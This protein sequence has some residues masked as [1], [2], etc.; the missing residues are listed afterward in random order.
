MVEVDT[1]VL[2]NAASLSESMALVLMTSL[3]DPLS[4]VPPSVLTDEK[5]LRG[6]ALSFDDD[7][8]KSTHSCSSWTA[9]ETQTYVSCGDTIS[10]TRSEFSTRNSSQSPM[11]FLLAKLREVMPKKCIPR[12]FSASKMQND[13]VYITNEERQH[14]N[15]EVVNL[16]LN[17]DI[18]SLML[19]HEGREEEGSRPLHTCNDF[20]ETLLHA[21]CR[22]GHFDV[23][24][25]LIEDAGVSP[26]VK[27]KQGVT[28]WHLAF[29]A[30]RPN[31][32]FLRFLLDEDADLLF[33][34]DDRGYAPL[35]CAPRAS[36]EEWIEVLD[37][38]DIKEFIPNRPVF[39][40]ASPKHSMLNSATGRK[41]LM[42]SIEETLAEK[43]QDEASS[44]DEDFSKPLDPEPTGT[45]RTQ[46][47]QQEL[48]SVMLSRL[49]TDLPGQSAANV[50]LVNGLAELNPKTLIETLHVRQD[51]ENQISAFSTMERAYHERQIQHEHLTIRYETRKAE[52]QEAMLAVQ[53]AAE[54]LRV[55]EN[56]LQV[57]SS[58]LTEAKESYHG[59]KEEYLVTKKELKAYKKKQSNCQSSVQ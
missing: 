45:E 16:V 11:S 27:D 47:L 35:D 44:I 46:Q 32:D 1:T 42:A 37:A 51:L 22:R 34:T 3:R 38:F 36:W 31:V 21:A 49:D 57:T 23:V 33:V 14:Y 10:T 56:V 55:A 7:L 19:L 9:E 39:S 12:T 43:E 52:M 29:R 4:Q 15:S 28:P 18:L 24:E 2:K 5:P 26:W 8:T 40:T 50:S 54:E 30:P 17:E 13:F 41:M 25:F 20:G 53:K 48:A 6:R 58:R 59:W